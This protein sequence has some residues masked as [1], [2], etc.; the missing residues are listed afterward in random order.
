MNV[1]AATSAISGTQDLANSVLSPALATA[2]RQLRESRTAADDRPLILVLSWGK[3]GDL[4][5][6][7]PL[8]HHLRHRFGRAR[9]AL[10]IETGYAAS[11]MDTSPD[12]DDVIVL[13]AR[14]FPE[15][16]QHSDAT[17]GVDLWVNCRYVVEYT[18]TSWGRRRF[19]ASEQTFIDAAR[20]RQKPWLPLLERFPFDNDQLWRRAAGQGLS[21][22]RLM[23]TTA[24][25]D[26]ADFELQRLFLSQRDFDAKPALPARYVTICNAAEMLHPMASGWTKSLPD[27]KMARVIAML[28]ARGLFLVQLGVRED[29][30]L[31]DVDL[32]L[33]GK[34]S[35]TEAAAILQG[36]VFHI[37]PEGGL[38]NIASS[39]GTRSI[40][41]FG[42]TPPSFFALSRNANILP[43]LCGG[44][45]WT[46]SSYL[47]ACPRLLVQ[48]ECTAS[49]DESEVAQ[50]VDA[51]MPLPGPAWR[52]LAVDDS[53]IAA[54]PAGGGIRSGVGSIWS[55][56]RGRQIRALVGD[57]RLVAPGARLLL[58]GATL[59]QLMPLMPMLEGFGQCTVVTTQSG[60]DEAG[61]AAFVQQWPAV[62]IAGAALHNIPCQ[63]ASMDLCLSLVD[64][65]DH[66]ATR[67]A[68][69]IVPGGEWLIATA[70]P[71]DRMTQQYDCMNQTLRQLALPALPLP[72][73]PGQAGPFDARLLGV[74][75]RYGA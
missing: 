3:L 32:D 43:K 59:R 14:H 66:V 47:Y 12:V 67:V 57:S 38:T 15:F 17:Q 62:D 40:V 45:W 64:V 11:M 16:I 58:I 21:M 1:L 50:A 60:H 41:F 53:S 70:A 56:G 36:A 25:F 51:L 4:L 2:C 24:G 29:P 52:V 54:L 35:P 19:S 7:S 46:T 28:K 55:D 31:P 8:L 42:S 23:A 33:R 44:C 22:Y 26:G 10:V 27:D 18:L 69:L 20:E 68:R 6:I 37:G 61:R 48:P 75:V 65:P 9:V 13:A 74:R 49:I 73:G 30:R 63:D 72:D 34:S 5:Q 39:V 71:G